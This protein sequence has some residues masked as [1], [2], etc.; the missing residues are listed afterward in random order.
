MKFYQVHLTHDAGVSAG[1]E[2]FT[3]LREA[4]VRVIAWHKDHEGV[5]ADDGSTGANIQE[6][7][8]VPTKVGILRALNLYANHADNG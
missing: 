6:I 1:Y 8:V 5:D 3:S 4:K 2:Y 7:N